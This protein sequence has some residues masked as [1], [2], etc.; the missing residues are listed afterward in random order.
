[1]GKRKGGRVYCPYCGRRAK[2]VDSKEVY[3]QSHGLIWLC[4]TCDARVGVHPES[5]QFK[6]LGTLANAETRAWRQRAHDAFDPLWRAKMRKEGCNRSKARQAGYEWLA[7]QLDIPIEECHIGMM[8]ADM[9][10]RVIAVIQEVQNENVAH[11][12]NH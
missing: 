9:C 8:D 1:M 3:G 6:P 4:R 12:R 2:L 5:S 10:Q 11:D 7:Q